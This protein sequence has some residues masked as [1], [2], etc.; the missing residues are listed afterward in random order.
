MKFHL[1]FNSKSLSNGIWTFFYSLVSSAICYKLKLAKQSFQLG[2]TTIPGF[3]RNLYLDH[4]S[5]TSRE[6]LSEENIPNEKFYPES[7]VS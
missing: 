3:K 1:I 6:C 7:D 5:L 4:Y 2:H